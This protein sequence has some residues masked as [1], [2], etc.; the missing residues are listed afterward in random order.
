[1]LAKEPES[2]SSSSV[3]GAKRRKCSAAASAATVDR[4]GVRFGSSDA[5]VG[6]EDEI[7][8]EAFVDLQP[9]ASGVLT[10]CPGSQH[11]AGGFSPMDLSQLFHGSGD[12]TPCPGFPGAIKSP[13]EMYSGF[14]IP[15]ASLPQL[16]LPN[17]A[18]LDAWLNRSY[19]NFLAQKVENAC[20]QY[21]FRSRSAR[22]EQDDGQ[23]VERA[24]V[25]RL[26]D[27][28]VHLIFDDVGLG[29]FINTLEVHLTPFF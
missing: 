23:L 18:V 1:M 4:A 5:S 17:H 20:I 12:A 6:C 3:G 8:D 25:E 24:V 11:S 14:N 26:A 15:I 27:I 29:R 10:T 9:E 16:S 19:C 7:I 28:A 22:V 13:H 2:P 21:A